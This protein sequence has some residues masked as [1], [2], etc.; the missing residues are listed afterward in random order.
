MT[1]A[2]RE[3]TVK[4]EKRKINMLG[5]IMRKENIENL[6]I[7]GKMEGKRCRGRQ[8]KQMLDDEVIW[9]GLAKTTEML[10]FAR[11]KEV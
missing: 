10:E 9:L 4:T 2:H 3:C 8:R 11:R 7:T 1:N 5:H 6:I